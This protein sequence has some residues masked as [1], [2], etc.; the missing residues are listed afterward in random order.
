[1]YDKKGY[2]MALVRKTEIVQVRVDVDLMESFKASCALLEVKPSVR[3]R[4]LMRADAA[5]V[6]RKAAN[7]AAWRASKASKAAQATEVPTVPEKLNV[8]PP[9][10]SAVLFS[11][12]RKL[13]KQAKAALK[14]K[15]EE[16][17]LK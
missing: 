12:R 15:R 6:A 5:E 16:K 2:G 8:E 1:M 10:R 4:A 3:L 7:A 9:V 17:W 13:D 14:K 11:E